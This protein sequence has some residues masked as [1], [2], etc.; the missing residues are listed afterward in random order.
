MVP[1][2]PLFREWGTILEKYF[3]NQIR[4]RSG[5]DMLSS[6]INIQP[7]PYCCPSMMFDPLIMSYNYSQHHIHIICGLHLIFHSDFF[8]FFWPRTKLGP[9]TTCSVKAG[10]C[11]LQCLLICLYSPQI[12]CH[13]SVTPLLSL[14][15][16]AGISFQ[17]LKKKLQN[18][19][20]RKNLN[21]QV[22]PLGAGGNQKQ[23]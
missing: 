15:L 16:A 6:D 22:F 3:T 11:N 1:G 23:R 21:S 18:I 20:Q 9:I 8:F 7:D 13:G 10:T 17:F 14:F 2:Y 5:L 4:L 19:T 12:Y